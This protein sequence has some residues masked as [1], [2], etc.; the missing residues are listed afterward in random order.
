MLDSVDFYCFSPT[1]GTKKVG[2]TLAGALAENV[3]Q[4]DLGCKKLGRDALDTDMVIVAVPVF[5]GRIPAAIPGKLRSLDG[6]G[7]KAVTLVVYGT[8][9]YED[10]LVELNDIL[11]AS[12]F[13]IVASGAFVAQH[14]MAP[15]VGAG[16]PDQDDIQEIQAFAQ[17][18]LGKLEQGAEGEIQVPGDRPYKP[19]FSAPATPLSLPSC[20]QC[21]RCVSVCPTGSIEL[22]G[23]SV[24]TD[25]S[26]CM[27]CMA[28][29]PVCPEQARILPPPLREKMEQML[30]ALKGI[31]RENEMFI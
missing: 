15:E 9:A 8:R 28:C 16:R 11:T 12:G 17:Q 19:D 5:G 30:G 18:I 3:N 20:T 23:G 4:I 1:G 21:G 14:S 7:R 27:L 26:A 13:Q 29:I 10:A 25:P 6:E 24:W 2:E 22:K 31:H